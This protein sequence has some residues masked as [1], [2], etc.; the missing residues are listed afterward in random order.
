M[1]IAQ[2]KNLEPQPAQT[3]AWKGFVV[4]L[5]DLSHWILCSPSSWIR[6]ANTL[7]QHF[8]CSFICTLKKDLEFVTHPPLT[9]SLPPSHL[10]LPVSADLEGTYRAWKGPR[11]KEF[12]PLVFCLEVPTT[13]LRKCSLY[14]W[15]VNKAMGGFLA[16]PNLRC[17]KSKPQNRVCQL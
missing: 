16:T 5:K 17:I 1:P 15:W 7:G 8:P 12:C 14:Q 13:W 10:P 2:E 4:P 3:V 11:T 6:I 9:L